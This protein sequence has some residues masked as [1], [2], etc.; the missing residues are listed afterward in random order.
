MEIVAKEISEQVASD[1]AKK[2]LDEKVD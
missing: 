2:H 1:A